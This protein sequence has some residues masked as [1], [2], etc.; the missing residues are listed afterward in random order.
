MARPLQTKA[1]IAG[2]HATEP[3]L[4]GLLLMVGHSAAISKQSRNKQTKSL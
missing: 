4:Q 2:T 3:R 1:F